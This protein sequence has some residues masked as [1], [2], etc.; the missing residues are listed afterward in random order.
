MIESFI[1]IYNLPKKLYYYQNKKDENIQYNY[2]IFYIFLEK[3][4]ML[5]NIQFNFNIQ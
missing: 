2:N 4:N 1:K 3:N 5:N